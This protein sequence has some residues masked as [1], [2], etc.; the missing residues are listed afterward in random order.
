VGQGLGGILGRCGCLWGPVARQEVPRPETEE[1]VEQGK[2]AWR[3]V[4]E[5]SGAGGAIEFQKYPGL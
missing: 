2:E 3:E 1:K 5:G 4:W